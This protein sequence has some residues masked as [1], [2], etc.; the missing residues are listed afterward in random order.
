MKIG[1]FI[2]M[3]ALKHLGKTLERI[4]RF[5]MNLFTFSKSLQNK[6]LGP[7]SKGWW[8]SE[9]AQID[10]HREIKTRFCNRVIMVVEL[11]V[12]TPQIRKVWNIY[13]FYEWKKFIFSAYLPSCTI[14]AYTYITLKRLLSS[15]LNIY[16][17][18]FKNE[19]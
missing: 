2:L 18:L 12:W 16:T 7:K 11:Q 5:F 14:Y 8:N 15:A 3:L 10:R 1:L 9:K 17:I 6:W 19:E 13:L 4:C